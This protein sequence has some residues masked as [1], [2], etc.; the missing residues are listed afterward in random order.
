MRMKVW[1]IQLALCVAAVVVAYRYGAR[2][3][4]LKLSDSEQLQLMRNEILWQ[5]ASHA[6]AQKPE[7]ERKLSAERKKVGLAYA[8]ALRKRHR[9][10]GCELRLDE[11]W[12]FH[13]IPPVFQ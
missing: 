2:G 8:T 1:L 4:D 5:N 12:L 7:V 6:E 11:N 9:C 10:E 3:P 13:I